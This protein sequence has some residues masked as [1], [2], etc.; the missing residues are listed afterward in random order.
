MYGNIQEVVGSRQNGEKNVEIYLI[1]ESGYV[2]GK[3]V[4]YWNEHGSELMYQIVYFAFILKIVS[5]SSACSASVIIGGIGWQDTLFFARVH[6][7]PGRVKWERQN[8]SYKSYTLVN[9][10]IE[11]GRN[12]LICIRIWDLMRI[13]G[14]SPIVAILFL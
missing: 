5:F 4:G 6:S 11:I 10:C 8:N 9:K 3:W 2:R 12:R 1:H 13:I 7:T 14:C